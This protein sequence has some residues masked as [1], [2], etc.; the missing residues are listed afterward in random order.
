MLHGSF[1]IHFRG[2]FGLE[3]HIYEDKVSEHPTQ[4]K[5]RRELTACFLN[6]VYELSVQI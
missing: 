2:S 5:V 6:E 3:L 4:Q 1:L